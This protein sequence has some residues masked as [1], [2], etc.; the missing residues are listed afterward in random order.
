MTVSIR[1]YIFA[2][3]GLQRIS[4]RVMDGLVHGSDAMPQFAGTKQ[5]VA[6]VIV[7]LEEGKPA[8]IT[9]ADGNFL[10][11]D[12]AGKVH[13]SLINSGFEAMDTF[14]A[15]ERSKRI[16]SKS[17]VVDLSPKLNREKW[18]RDNRWTLSK[19]DLDLISDDIWKRNRAA[20]P[21]VQ[22]AKGAAPKPPP[23]TL[24]AKE[25][26]REIQTHIF[27][28]DGKMDYLTEPALKGFAFEARRLAKDDFDNAVWLG[29]A[30]AADRRRE[31]LARYRTGSGIWYASVDVIRW[32]T[33]RR[34]GRTDSFV[35]ERC[36]S[37]K[38]AEET[39]RRLL[40]ENAKHFSAESSVEARVVCDLEWAD[41]ASGDV[42]E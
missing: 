27:G 9:R 17:K 30:E 25:A 7:E 31:I 4:Q 21:I 40:A 5:K 15:L 11:F 26:I 2:D 41:A 36:N 24:E 39:A 28:I 16:K 6:N 3:D 33:S 10:H 23:V 20:T 18:E 1:F 19:Q 37:K 13:E 8:R 14:D 29:I 32:D 22:Q 42:D 12:A 34:T 35:H 38:E